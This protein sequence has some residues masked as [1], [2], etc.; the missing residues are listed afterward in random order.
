[1]NKTDD[2]PSLVFSSKNN[3]NECI[4]YGPERGIEYYTLY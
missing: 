4:R 1:M 2:Q 3:R